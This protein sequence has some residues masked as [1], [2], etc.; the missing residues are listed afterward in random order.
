MMKFQEQLREQEILELS[1]SKGFFESR[2]RRV[3]EEQGIRGRRVQ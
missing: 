1:E 3:V 2:L